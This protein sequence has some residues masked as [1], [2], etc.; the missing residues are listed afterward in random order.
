M[1]LL[2]RKEARRTFIP[3]SSIPPA[4]FT[5]PTLYQIPD[6]HTEPDVLQDLVCV[7]PVEVFGDG[8]MRW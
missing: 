3:D 7:L 5:V 6:G 1:E 2:E 8:D 4:N